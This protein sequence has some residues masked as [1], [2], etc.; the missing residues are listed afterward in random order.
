MIFRAKVESG[1]EVVKPQEVV[2]EV[3]KPKEV[4]DNIPTTF[5]EQSGE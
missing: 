5:S 3:V 2:E 4:E 1:A